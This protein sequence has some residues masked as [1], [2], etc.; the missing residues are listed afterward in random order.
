MAGVTIFHTYDTSTREVLSVHR[1][2]G[3]ANRAARGV[4]GRT[5]YRGGLTTAQDF[6]ENAVDAMLAEPDG[7]W[8][9][10]PAGDTLRQTPTPGQYPWRDALHGYHANLDRLYALAVSVGPHHPPAH[11][12]FVLGALFGSHQVAWAVNRRTGA[13][14]TQKLRWMQGHAA[15]PVGYSPDDPET[16]ADLVD[17]LTPA[18]IDGANLSTISFVDWGTWR[19]RT[20]LETI[21]PANTF[22][23]I[24]DGARVHATVRQLARGR[25]IDSVRE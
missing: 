2:Q 14:T 21:D 5:A 17:A 10:W 13:T 7:T 20:L 4:S 12:T 19:R 3:E 22:A 25:W 16:I 23:P 15:G 6:E 11:V 1:T 24:V 8:Y 18:Q 9:S